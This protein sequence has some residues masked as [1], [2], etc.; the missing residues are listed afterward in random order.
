VRAIGVSNFSI[1]HLEAIINATGVVPAVNQ[2]E[3]HPSLIQKDLYAYC[4]LSLAVHPFDGDQAV[5][6]LIRQG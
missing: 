6:D 1:A 5:P 4:K 3:G 2:I